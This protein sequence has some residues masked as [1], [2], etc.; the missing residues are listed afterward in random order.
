[1]TRSESYGIATTDVNAKTQ[2]MVV[3]FLTLAKIIKSS[4]TENS[5]IKK[6]DKIVME[7]LQLRFKS[8]F[9]A[10]L[11]PFI[12]TPLSIGVICLVI[13]ISITFLS[14][15]FAM[16]VLLL[17]LFYRLMPKILTIQS[18]FQLF[19]TFAP[20]LTNIDKQI[21]IAK[22][23]NEKNGKLIF[24]SLSDS[25][26][27]VDVNFSYDKNITDLTLEKININIKKG[28][29]TALV[30]GSGGGKSTISDICL[31]L[32]TPNSGTI[33]VDDKPLEDL[34]KNSYRRK[35]GY[36][37][38]D[39]QLFN[40]SVKNN[41]AWARPE[42][43]L[44]EIESATKQAFAHDF[45]LELPNKYNTQLGDRGV[46][47]SGGQRQRICLARAILQNPEILILDE[48]TSALDAESEKKIHDAVTKLRGNVTILIIAHRL[49][50]V[51]T[52]DI[53]YVIENGKI[54]E[55]GS[56]ATLVNSG[57]RFEQLRSLQNL[58]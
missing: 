11:V 18:T 34:D 14:L 23:Y 26:R 39:A 17:A 44:S 28:G 40:D 5:A 51:K 50:T 41:I 32:I 52:A 22:S 20:G 35:V 47:I 55:E 36:V 19:L 2:S 37:T 57:T 4:S 12:F 53:V 45:I 33:L 13:Y 6:L 10:S 48:A 54:L 30:G 31:G 8:L 43:T 42:A 15:D 25:I 16:V 29:I 27:L 58:D 1:M 56:W 49:A 46:R 38:Q 3:D 9:N 7:R 24:N 21:N